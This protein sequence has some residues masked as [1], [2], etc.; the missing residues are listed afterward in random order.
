MKPIIATILDDRRTKKSGKYPV[1]VRITFLR[2]RKYYPVGIDLTEDEFGIIQNEEAIKKITPITLRRHYT[3]LKLK[4]D[5]KRIK[6]KDIIEKMPDFTFKLFE[7]KF[8]TNQRSTENVYEYYD[9]VIKKLRQDGRMGT[10]DNYQCSMNSLKAFSP[11][12]S[13]RDVSVE[14]LN[15]Y[16]KWLLAQGKSISTVGIYVRPLRAIL[17]GAIE[18]GVISREAHYPFGRRRYQIPASKNKKKAL[19]INEI[20]R[21]YYYPAIAGTWHERA[22]DFFL[23]S[24]FGNGINMKDIA[25]LRYR[26]IDGEF[27]RFVRAK[28][29]HT[30][31][32]AS[33]PISIVILK[34]MQ[35]II[36]RWK[37]QVCSP[38][39][40]LFPI[41]SHGLTPYKEQAL[42]RQFTKMVNK[43]LKLITKD[44]G[45]EKPVTTYYARHS[46]ATVLR[47]SG[48]STEI[49]SESLGH[50]NIRTTS[51][52]LDSFD[53]DTRKETMVNLTKF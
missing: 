35:E 11:K 37:N 18:E 8:Y 31:R 9:N 53:D 3:D 1:K 40:Y 15:D 29:Q 46:F 42:I 12:L 34:E 24:Y 4:C 10:S 25:L 14:F 17:N 22:R 32:T 52:Y 27:I 16:E 36:D 49:I 33:S 48:T 13:L 6:A 7:K 45:I 20:G 51:S 5:A 41:L 38:D 39:N 43:Y 23:F 28:T 26:D 2:D 47:R 19:T 21:I 50:T 44:V 30:N